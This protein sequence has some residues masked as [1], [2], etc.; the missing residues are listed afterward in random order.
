MRY[1]GTE[2]LARIMVE[3]EDQGVVSEAATRL[4]AHFDSLRP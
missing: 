2:K 3:G 1:S 4:A